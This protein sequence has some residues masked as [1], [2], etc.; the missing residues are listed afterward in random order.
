M[1]C[2]SG[3]PGVPAVLRPIPSPE[4][5]LACEPPADPDTQAAPWLFLSF[6]LAP[7]VVIGY[8]MIA[9]AD[10]LS[11]AGVPLGSVSVL[12]TAAFVPATLGFLWA[13]LLDV[14]GRRQHWVLGGVLLLCVAVA[15][16]VSAPRTASALPWLG[17][18]SALAGLGY[19]LV[20]VGQKGLAVTLFEPARRVVAAGW[21]GTGSG[22]GLAVGGGMLAA[23][24]HLSMPASALLLV[25]VAGGPAVA[26]LVLVARQ[27]PPAPPEASTLRVVVRDTGRLLG[28]T[29]GMFALAVCVLPFGS[30]AAA[31]MVGAL[32]PDFHASAAFVGA[33]AGTAKSLAY[34]AGALLGARLCVRIGN[35]SGFFVC[36]I[37]FIAF[38]LLMLAAPRTP[39][40]YGAMVCGYGFLQGAS[41]SAILGIILRT[42]EP[43]AAATQAAVL[44]AAGNL[45]NVY[46]PP[47]AGRAHDAGGLTGLLL[48]D[49]AIGVGGLLLLLLFARLI[50]DGSRRGDRPRN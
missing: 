18:L 49:A 23:A 27:L 47:I 6:G 16:L 7:A 19:S 4:E 28:T 38:A 21:A 25:L 42:V 9:V 29:P 3:L 5:N 15:G 32:G 46:L 43:R 50:G 13:P 34:A 14:V 30:S 11:R 22:I 10:E 26:S 17:A 36:G 39:I 44:V 37:A 41:V 35:R 45:A 31:L 33:W 24:P 2:I 12:V 8:A 48:A 1:N 40:G 20:S